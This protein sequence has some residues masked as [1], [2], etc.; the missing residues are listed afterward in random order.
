MTENRTSSCFCGAVEISVAGDPVTQGYCHC[1]SCG[2]WT[3]QPVLAYAL[4]PTEKVTFV[5]GETSL[6]TG[7]RNHDMTMRFCTQCGGNVMAVSAYAGLTDVFPMRIEGFDF[8]PSYHV[9]YAERA[10]DMRDGLP[11]FSDM[12][13]PADGSGEVMPE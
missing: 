6:G 12:P 3:A 10:I 11:K 13:E 7:R 5:K 2:A 1:T 9:N 4:W 8:Q